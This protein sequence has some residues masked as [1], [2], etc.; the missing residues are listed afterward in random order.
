MPSGRRFALVATAL[1]R[2]QAQGVPALTVKRSRFFAAPM[3]SRLS[4]EGRV[5]CVLELQWV[6][7]PGSRGG[8]VD[9]QS[10]KPALPT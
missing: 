6:I 9:D 8:V 2:G 4:V 5:V 3:R 1:V 7:M 10:T